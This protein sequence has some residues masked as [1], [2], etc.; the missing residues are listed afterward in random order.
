MATFL[1][2]LGRLSYRRR[3]R[4]LAAWVLVLALAGLGAAT[5]SGPMSNTFSVPGTESQAALD[6]VEER[7][8]GSGADGATARVVFV[9]D[10]GATVA[11]PDA[12][13]AVAQTVEE[14][15]ALPDVASV[16][17]P[18]E[19][20][21]VSRD[22]S[23]AYA[24][25]SYAVQ[26]EQ[27]T[28]EERERLFD[29]GGA[30][31]DAGLSVHVGGEAAQGAPEEQASE[32]VGMGVAAVVLV[33]T[34]GSLLAAG[35]PLVTAVVGVGL[36]SLGLAIAAGFTDLSATSGTL[37]TMLGLAVAIDYSLFVVSRH[38]HELLT[39]R[40]GEESAGRAVGTAGSAVVFAGATVVIAL[41]ALSVVGIPF[42][43]AMGLAAAATV[44]IAV[45]VA[46]TLLPALLGFLGDRV[47]G[48][49]GRAARD[50]EGDDAPADAPDDATDAR[51]PAPAHLAHPAQRAP[52]GARW[53]RLVVRRRVVAL[54]A[55]VVG[56]GVVAVPALDMRLG[57][58][59]DATAPEDSTQRQ[60]YEAVAEGFG[61]GFNGPLLVTADLSDA[62]GAQATATLRRDLASLDGVV[63]A[64]PPRTSPAGDLALYTVVPASGPDEAATEDLVH[65]VRDRA[66]GWRDATG[67]TVQV[68]GATAVAIDVSETLDDALLP[69]L[70]VV[71]GLAFV[72][73][74]L[75]FRSLVVP[76]K[77]TL[78]FLLSMAA[79]FG[80]VVAVFQKGWGADLLG[81]AA[82]GPVLSFLPILLVGLL[83]G[84]AMD[85][86][87]FLV[88]RMRE[89]HVHGAPAQDAVV[90]G[91]RHGARVVTAAAVIMVSV[92]A[93]FVLSDENVVKSMGFALATGVLFDAF[94]VRMTLVPAVMSLLGEK[95]WALPRW[96]DRVLPDV[97]VEGEQL[98]QLPGTEAPRP[99]VRS[100]V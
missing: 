12:R 42:L 63:F 11:S 79:T 23:T 46:L 8:P 77:A 37:A 72:L 6:L 34:F 9:A 50:T 75:V 93:G 86:E 33:L 92:F 88:T 60:A 78:G 43:T 81:V 73:L 65:R 48:R 7:M 30:A 76:F 61:P 95:A 1:Y 44:A 45:V 66:P 67:A 17:D 13:A 24:T 47:L 49:R 99:E 59:S 18:Y 57:M 51:R 89:E 62:D 91:F 53:A 84:L 58:P 16:A 41:S 27:I 38:R 19:S 31:E 82:T 100:G 32:A 22:G 56:L 70:A 20:R 69:Y 2:R 90:H 40:T 87:V 52:M 36:G 4:V 85:Y 26:A 71:V 21:A 39:G 94:L 68:T 80:A 28:P 55:V 54:L 98:T 3:G 25:V 10:D 14:L 29:V 83:F 97:D 74:L 5:L 64:S 96:L 35:L 15:R